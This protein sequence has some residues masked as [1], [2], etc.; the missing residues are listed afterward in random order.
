MFFS[1]ILLSQAF[2]YYKEEYSLI[3]SP[4]D[5]SFLV[6]SGIL[7]Q[8]K[9]EEVWEILAKKAEAVNPTRYSSSGFTKSSD[10]LLFGILPIMS[11]VISLGS[12]VMLLA[13]SA[14]IGFVQ[15]FKNI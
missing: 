7:H 12:V 15:G 2:G 1:L 9:A 5:L 3:V 14:L 10:S 11:L 4:D 8:D 6:D 13:F